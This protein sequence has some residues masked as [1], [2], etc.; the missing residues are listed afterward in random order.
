MKKSNPAFLKTGSLNVLASSTTFDKSQ[1]TLTIVNHAYVIKIVMTKWYILGFTLKY[2]DD[3]FFARKEKGWGSPLPP[4]IYSDAL[5]RVSSAQ[6]PSTPSRSI[7]SLA[8]KIKKIVSTKLNYAA[9]YNNILG[10]VAQ[11]NS[12][13]G[14]P[15]RLGKKIKSTLLPKTRASIYTLKCR[16]PVKN[17]KVKINSSM[18]GAR[19]ISNDSNSVLTVLYES[20]P[21]LKKVINI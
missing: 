16:G 13:V 7:R 17:H 6:I 18:S 14:K 21:Y 20:F 12:Y 19:D 1:T 10:V 5:P 9:A 3:D 15:N 11:Y 8:N 2:A 4:R